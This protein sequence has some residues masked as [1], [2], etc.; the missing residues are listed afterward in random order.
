MIERVIEPT[1]EE[2]RNGWDAKAL[3]K[4]LADRE[5]SQSAAL[6]PDSISRRKRPNEQNHRY[7]PLRWRG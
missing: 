3:N 5:A 1:D 2:K 6:D 4:Y 7:R